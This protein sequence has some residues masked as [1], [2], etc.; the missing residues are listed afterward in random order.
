MKIKRATKQ[1]VARQLNELRREYLDARRRNHSVK[2]CTLRVYI[3]KHADLL[4]GK[5]DVAA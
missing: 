5:T 3:Q 1:L 2:A 4:K